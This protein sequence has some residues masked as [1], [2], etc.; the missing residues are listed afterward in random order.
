MEIRPPAHWILVPNP[1]PE[2]QFPGV[3]I[4]SDWR[5]SEPA[6]RVSLYEIGMIFGGLEFH[7]LA[8]LALDALTAVVAQC[9]LGQFCIT[10]IA[11]TRAMFFPEPTKNTDTT[12]ENNEGA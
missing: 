4:E 2:W 7:R 3:P 10:G 8:G 6:A 5:L 12:E 9:H 1:G 11:H